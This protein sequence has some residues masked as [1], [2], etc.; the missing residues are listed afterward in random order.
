MSWITKAR[1]KGLAKKLR[2]TLENFDLMSQS[3]LEKQL[4][5]VIH[6]IN[7]TFNGNEFNHGDLPQILNSK[8]Y[9]DDTVQMLI[10]LMPLFGQQTN[11]E[12]STLFQSSI[13]ENTD[14]HLPFYLIDRPEVLDLL[15]SY[16]NYNNLSSTANILLRS[17]IAIREFTQFLYQK[18]YVLSFIRFLASDNFELTT[19]AFKTF[20]DMLLTY[21]EIT[22]SYIIDNYQVYSLEFKTLLASPVYLIKMLFLPM[23]FQLLAKEECRALMMIFLSDTQNLQLI[24]PLLRS[25]SKKIKHAAYNIFK[26]FVINPRKTH[27]ITRVLSMNKVALVKTIRHIHISRSATELLE[28]RASLIATLRTL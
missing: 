15:F 19:A 8:I 25:D 13:R 7:E 21:P 12:I 9:R 10:S 18:Q 24:I 1:R 26:L 17:C 22:Y 23:L 4:V 6:E 27:A 2:V 16:L 28:E 3:E 20:E 5:P 14:G 11:N